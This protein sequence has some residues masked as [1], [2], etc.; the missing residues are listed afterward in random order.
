MDFFGRQAAARGLSRWLLGAFA[1]ATGAVALAVALVL[2]VLINAAG[3][4]EGH[5]PSA[6]ADPVVFVIAAMATAAFIGLASLWRLS[7]LRS[8]GGAV[9]VSLGRRAGHRTGKGSAQAPAAQ[10]RRGN[11]D[12]GRAPRA[13]GLHPRE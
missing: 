10:R 4:P 9:A 6:T 13:G 2:A 3:T 12:R 7:G 8:G 11:G 5:L 1:I